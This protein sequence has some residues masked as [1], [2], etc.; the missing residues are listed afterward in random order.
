MLSLS[1]H[2]ALHLS[3][4]TI[5]INFSPGSLE[6]SLSLSL[7]LCLSSLSHA[8]V[9]DGFQV[10]TACPHHSPAQV[11]PCV[12]CLQN[13]F[14]SKSIFLCEFTVHEWIRF[15]LFVV[16]VYVVFLH[17]QNIEQFSFF[18]SN[19]KICQNL[20]RFANK[21]STTFLRQVSATARQVELLKTH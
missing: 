13:V 20:N 16:V 21:M 10:T 6:V 2:N 14:S 11:H 5:N 19:L 4:H 18:L 15:T 3:P 17:E 1:H 8:R 9:C 12:Y 7:S